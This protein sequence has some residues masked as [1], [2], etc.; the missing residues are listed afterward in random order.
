M[1]NETTFFKFGKRAKGKSIN[2]DFVIKLSDK[3]TLLLGITAETV[4]S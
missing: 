4:V 2:K 1:L 3:E